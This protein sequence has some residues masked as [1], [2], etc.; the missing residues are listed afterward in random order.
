MIEQNGPGFWTISNQLSILRGV[1]AIPVAILIAQG[2]VWW[3]FGLCWFAALTDWLDG[4]VARATNTVSEWGKILDPIADKILVG[5][6]VVMLVLEGLLPLRSV[7]VVV[8][9]DVIIL[10]ARCDHRDQRL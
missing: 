10:A 5:V 7:L 3:A 4:F 2:D 1:L 6:I 9:R 8:G